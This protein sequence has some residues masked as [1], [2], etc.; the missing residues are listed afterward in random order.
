MGNK[1]KLTHLKTLLTG[2]AKKAIGNL[3]LTDENYEPAVNILKKRFTCTQETIETRL[4]E[5]LHPPKVSK[6]RDAAGYHQLQLHMSSHLEASKNLGVV[7]AETKLIIGPAIISAL[8]DEA[9]AR[10][11][12]LPDA[13]IT[14]PKALMNFLGELIKSAE[15]HERTQT[16]RTKEKTKP[17]PSDQPTGSCSQLTT[18]VT[19]KPKGK[20][21][22]SPEATKKRDP[23]PYDEEDHATWSC[24]SLSVDK[25]LELVARE[26]RCS[27][28]LSRKHLLG[29]CKVKFPC[30]KCRENHHTSLCKGERGTS[31]VATA[32]PGP[33]TGGATATPATPKP[34]SSATLATTKVGKPNLSL[35]KTAT[36]FIIGPN[37][38]KRALCLIDD[39]AQNTFVR[40]A[41]AKELGL[42]NIEDQTMAIRSFGAAAPLTKTLKLTSLELRG[43]A[44]NAKS[45]IIRGLVTESITVAQ[46][47]LQT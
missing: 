16:G 11:S 3:Q 25:R 17:Q 9:V 31:G 36:I 8:P 34:T 44:P 14:D 10:W 18:S 5:L 4:K 35:L 38:K 15:R 24:T 43:T 2:A 28:C 22:S 37:G 7:D 45:I 21:A 6:Y 41:V 27:R 23:F 33:A 13:E 19:T 20:K 30:F 40:E 46:P 42:P 12:D 1:E 47:Y 26:K 39:G 32:T 29:H